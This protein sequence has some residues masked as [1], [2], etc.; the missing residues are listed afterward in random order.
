MNALQ[1]HLLLL[2]LAVFIGSCLFYFQSNQQIL[3]LWLGFRFNW[4]SSFVF[5][6]YIGF[7]S[8]VQFNFNLSYFSSTKQTEIYLIFT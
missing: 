5:F 2:Y 6:N 1:M 3:D 7:L 8:L 4:F